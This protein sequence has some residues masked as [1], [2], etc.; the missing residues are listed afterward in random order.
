ME[1]EKQR[2]NRL[3][4]STPIKERGISD[5]IPYA[6]S[7]LTS[8]RFSCSTSLTDVWLL[9]NPSALWFN[10]TSVSRFEFLPD[11][12]LNVEY[13]GA[14]FP[15]D[16]LVK[17]MKEKDFIIPGFQR[18]YVWT[19]EEASRFIESLLLGLPT[20]AL[21]LAK[22]KFSNKFLSLLSWLC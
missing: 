22:D 17:R 13:Y 11:S 1:E 15:V 19:E 7:K 4:T 12:R 16:V 14:D 3:I 21:F 8:C 10:P 9:T 2:R 20:P 18:Q 6:A 5:C